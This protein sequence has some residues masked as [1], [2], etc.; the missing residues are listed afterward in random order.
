MKITNYILAHV[1]GPM[2]DESITKD[3]EMGDNL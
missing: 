2:A 3:E 1:M